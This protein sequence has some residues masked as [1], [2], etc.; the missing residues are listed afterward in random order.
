M[1][2]VWWTCR[3]VVQY[4]LRPTGQTVTAD[5]YSQQLERVQQ[6]LHQ[7]EPALVNRKGA[8][9]LHDNARPHVERVARNTIQRLG[10][11]TLCHPPYST[12]LAPSDYHLFHSPDSHIRGKYCTN[13]ADVRQ[14]FTDFFASHIP[15]FYRK[16]IEQLKTLW[17]KGLDVDGDYFE[18]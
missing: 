3:Q 4:E 14:A 2:C 15:E 10:W 18:D 13:E 16:G 7:K 11:E 5:L 12:D 6:A 1:L 17:R 9:L 8:L